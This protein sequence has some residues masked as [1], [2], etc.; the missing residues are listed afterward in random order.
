MSQQR[1]EADLEVGAFGLTFDGP[2]RRLDFPRG[3]LDN[4]RGVAGALSYGASEVVFD[5]LHTRLDRTHWQAETAAAGGVFLR[6]EDDALMFTIGRVEMSHGVT[7]TRAAEGGVEMLAT[8]ASLL[9]VMLAM[10]D[11]AKLRGS[12]GAEVASV[13][14]AR[15]AEIPLRQSQLHWLDTLTGEISVT[16]KAVL[17]LPVIGTRTLD[18]KLTIPIKEGSLD[19][20][21]LDD[22]LDWLEGAFLD[23]IYK[24][25]R[26]VLTWRVPVFGSRR[27]IMSFE[28]DDEAKMLATFDRVPLRS[29]ADFRFPSSGEPAEAA[30]AK[31]KS[32][33][34]SLTMSDLK[35]N[36]SMVAPRS[37]EIGEGAIQ[38]G[39][40][41]QPGMVG[42]K[43]AG[44]LVHP[45]GPGGLTGTIG[46]VDVTTKDLALGPMTLTVDRLHL[47]DLDGFEVAFDGFRPVGLTAQ[48]HRV[49]AS[50]LVLRL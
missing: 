35:V 48:V 45:P 38:L 8:H 15:A 37:I 14:I 17:D 20:R 6:L 4:L 22:S 26:L 18:Q 43:L 10:P 47:G 29:L 50:N 34:R 23:L 24:N 7:I 21:A 36:L 39:G 2:T 1:L 30:P 13:A 32:I 28:L 40:E 46:L 41:G 11:L 44:T 12:R 31:K 19:F 33:L 25:E 3:E 42:L 9:D 5:K 27:E 49:S 16:I